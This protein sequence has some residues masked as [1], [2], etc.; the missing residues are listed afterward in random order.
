MNKKEVG[1]ILIFSIFCFIPI[2]FF[3]N[4]FWDS[5]IS[6][7]ITNWGS[8]GDYFGSFF[9]FFSVLVTIYI[10]YK[11][12]QIEKNRHKEFLKF[13]REKLIR[14]FREIEY[15]RIN[16]EL[17]K[18]WGCLTEENV[19]SLKEIIFNCIIQFRY[20]ISSN[21]HLFPFLKDEVMY[22]LK[23]SLEEIQKLISNQ[24][25]LNKLKIVGDFQN[26]FDAFNKTVQKFLLKNN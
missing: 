24:N 7:D 14:E 26:N 6:K 15:K 17:Q 9:S 18:V 19:G 4:T 16:L 3:V 20:F 5:M 13:E 11:L 10:A 12:S 23:N 21:Q 22:N 25:D 2:V 1:L 8:F